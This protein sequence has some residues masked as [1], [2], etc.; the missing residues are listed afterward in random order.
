MN[1]LYDIMRHMDSIC[2]GRF[3]GADFKGCCMALIGPAYV[4]HIKQHA[5][6]KYLHVF[7]KL[8]GEIQLPFV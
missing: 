4:E 5:A 6:E 8:K 1:T 2:G 7:P 3:S